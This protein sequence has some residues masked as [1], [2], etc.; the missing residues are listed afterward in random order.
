MPRDVRGMAVAKTLENKLK[1]F[2]EA[3]PLMT[4]LK[5]EALRERHWKQ[6]MKETGIEFDMNPETFTLENLFAMELHRFNEVIQGIVTSASKELQIEKGVKEV[7]ETW[8]KLKFDVFKYTKGTQDRGYIIGAVDEIM[9]TLDDNTMSLQS[10]SA[11]RFIGPF[12]N[13]VQTWEKSLSL[14]SEVIDVC[15]S[16][17]FSTTIFKFSNFYFY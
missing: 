6:L 17:I 5:H 7:I 11:S 10:M 2:K 15:A 4:D 13:T 1:S 12:L 3:L 9:Q 8:E 14:I 16:I